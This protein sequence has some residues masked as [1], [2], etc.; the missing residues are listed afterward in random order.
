MQIREATD[1][2][3]ASIWPF[4]H[5]I[6]AAGETFT[7]PTD[8]DEPTGRAMWMVRAPGRVVVAV[9]EDGTVL[10]TAN[11]YAN[12]MGPGAHIASGSFMVAPEHSGHGVGRALCTYLLAWAREHGFRGVQFNA[13]A[14]SNTRAVGLYESLGFEV[15][16]TIPEGFHHPTLGYVGLHI[17]YQR[18]V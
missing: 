18:L 5:A 4:F 2:D 7:Y 17:M 12:K 10:G 3:W 8:V 9:D 15:M 14:A 11:M 1:A 13:V 16:T 6:T